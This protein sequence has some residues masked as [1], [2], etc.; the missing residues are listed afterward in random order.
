MNP[1]LKGFTVLTICFVTAGCVGLAKHEAEFNPG[2][3]SAVPA[4]F[5]VLL[6]TNCTGTTFDFDITEELRK[7]LNLQLQEQRLD[8]H[9]SSADKH[10]LLDVEILDYIKGNA[11]GRWISPGIG[12]TLLDV[13][14]VITESE[15]GTNVGKVKALRT[16]D[17]GGLY[18]VG[19]WKVIFHTVAKDIVGELKKTPN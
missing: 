6:V 2:Y 14:C 12:K 9:S 4:E 3:A 1:F 19:Q 15:S 8:W 11:F 18:S 16:I 5:E 17:C 13:Q 7:Q 10:L